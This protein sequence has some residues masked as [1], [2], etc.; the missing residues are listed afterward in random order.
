MMAAAHDGIAAL[1]GPAA[2]GLLTSAERRRLDR[3]LERCGACR[4]ELDELTAVVGRLGELEG[5]Q[6][7]LEDVQADPARAEAV[8]SAI[9]AERAHERRRA[10][11]WQLVFAAAASVAVLLAGVVTATALTRDGESKVPL[12]PVSVQAAGDVRARADLVAHTWGVEI[13]LTATG[14]PAGQPYTVQ[15]RTTSGDLVNAGAFLGTGERT[16]FCNLNASVLRSD[17]AEFR[18]LD[19]D[20][21]QVLSAE[22]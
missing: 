8:V 17:A 20:G 4:D 18:V 11:R 10:Q 21:A 15:V 19:A 9:A 13:K 14:L 3:H 7:L 2:L 12:E 6:G 5:E 16:L 22:L 1:L